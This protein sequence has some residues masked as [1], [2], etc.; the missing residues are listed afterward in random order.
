MRAVDLPSGA[1]A[2]ERGVEQARRY[3]ESHQQEC[4][5]KQ[6]AVANVI[7]HIVPGFVAEDEKR[8]VRGHFLQ[9]RV[10]DDHTLGSAESGDVSVQLVGF[11]TGTHQE[12][13]IGGNLQAG[14]LRDFHQI[15]GKQRLLRGKRLK[16]EE[17]RINDERLEKKHDE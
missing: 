12:H 1:P 14:A 6:N 7:E 9:Q 13:M 3:V 4:A 15:L 5:K 8:F 16:F 11:L 17:G 2:V 10:I